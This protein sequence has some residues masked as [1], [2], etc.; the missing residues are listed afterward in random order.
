MPKSVSIEQWIAIH[1]GR[2]ITRVLRD[3]YRTFDGDL[4]MALV[5]GELGQYVAAP[6]HEPSRYRHAHGA[7]GSNVYSISAASGIPRQTVRRKLDRLIARGWI[8]ENP[9]GK[10]T[11]NLAHDPPLATLFAD[12]NRQLLQAMREAV[13]RLERISPPQ[14]Y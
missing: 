7:R 10:L 12:D 14:P 6:L 4:T 8:I 1:L 5:F 3:C 2:V 13:E 9:D 11:L